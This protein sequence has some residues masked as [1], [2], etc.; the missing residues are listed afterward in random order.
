M[1]LVLVEWVDS[2]RGDGWTR[3]EDLKDDHAATKCKSVG[4]VIA[5]DS[6]ALTLAGHIGENPE[7]CCGDMTIPLRSV[8]RISDVRATSRRKRSR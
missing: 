5:K 4:W 3:L 6:S 7:Q 2:R 1:R 8:I